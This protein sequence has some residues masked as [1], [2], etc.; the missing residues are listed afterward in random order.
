M[1]EIIK[2]QFRG[3]DESDKWVYR[4]CVGIESVLFNG[5]YGYRDQV[6]VKI[7]TICQ[8][9]GKKDKNGIEIYEKDIVLLK[10]RDGYGNIKEK[11]SV[12][13]CN[14][15]DFMVHLFD[16]YT[17]L[18]SNIMDIEV[19]GNIIDNEDLIF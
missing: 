2:K 6:P 18:I 16:D 19:I 10:Y 1:K 7:G 12:V 14:S 8:Y 15:T 11:K 9:S 4:D 5:L 3:K 17:P 13:F